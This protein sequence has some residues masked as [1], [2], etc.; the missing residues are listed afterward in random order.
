MTSSTL[1]RGGGS[2]WHVGG[3]VVVALIISLVVVVV[4]TADGSG[5]P[6]GPTVATVAEV[7]PLAPPAEPGTKPAGP[8]SSAGPDATGVSASTVRVG[9]QVPDQG[10]LAAIG[11]T[12]QAVD[13]EGM[14]RAFIDAANADGGIN[15]RAI[16]PVFRVVNPIDT[17]AMRA[18]CLAWTRDE[19]VFAVLALIGF[20]GPPV[21]CVTEE[22]G[23]PFI[24]ADGQPETWQ[25]NSGRGLLFSL[26]ANKSRVLRNYAD[27]LDRTNLLA[28]RTIGLIDNGGF[29]HETVE[30]VL[31]PELERRGYTVASR[32]TFSLDA[33]EQARQYPLAVAQ[34]RRDGVDTVVATTSYIATNG[35]M[36]AAQAAAFDPQWFFSS[37]SGGTTDLVAGIMPP[38]TRA[39]GL[40]VG[41]VGE[42]RV[43]TPLAPEDVECVRTYEAASGHSVDL[44]AGTELSSVLA[45]CG[46]VE[47]FVRGARNA[48]TELNRRTFSDG[49]SA[50]GDLAL[51][52]FGSASFR[53]GKYDGADTARVVQFT[54]SCTCWTPYPGS[55]LV[56]LPVP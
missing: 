25:D 47:V 10:L 54:A 50:I 31:V 51:P 39:L 20:Y 5:T 28:G 44:A 45:V 27:W 3:G 30:S 33:G 22:N 2:R 49:V 13:V 6:A 17:T 18:D 55:E 32:F 12:T 21:R 29:D 46:L 8:P 36:T 37:Y 35:A 15:G 34:L 56:P 53:P 16:E 41:R 19:R 42:S 38:G 43:G 48:G 14:W 40:A 9:V 4:A 11:A 26:P 7:N 23:T 24:G 52:G 1:R